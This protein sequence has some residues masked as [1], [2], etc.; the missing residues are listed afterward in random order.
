MRASAHRQA[1]SDAKSV[2]EA[3]RG[4]K[5]ERRTGREEVKD[6]DMA[7]GAARKRMV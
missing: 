4:T 6:T 7:R 1:A 5:V 2:C 3:E